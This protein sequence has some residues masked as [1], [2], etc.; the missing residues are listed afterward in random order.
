MIV[1]K[2]DLHRCMS[3]VHGILDL[4]IVNYDNVLYSF[5]VFGVIYLTL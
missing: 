5:C 2:N 1:S 3:H 4:I